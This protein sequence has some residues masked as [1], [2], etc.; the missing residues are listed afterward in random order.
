M[1]GGPPSHIPLGA[2][3][4]FD[5]IRR[6]AARWGMRAV[7]LGDDCAVLD[8]PEGERLVI[9]TDSSVE[10]VHFRRSWLSP[11]EIGWR[12]TAGALSDLAAMG[13]RPLGVMLGL[14]VPYE[15]RSALDELADGIGEAAA[16]G[17]APILGG[18]TSDGGVLALAVT[19]IGAAARPLPRSGARAGDRLYV[20]GVLGGSLGALRDLEAGRIPR[21]GM[22]QRFAHPEPR[23]R[24]G[25]WLAEQG[26]TA[27]VDI[28]DG[29]AADLGHLAAASGVRIAV[30]L[31]KLPVYEEADPRTGA[32][33]AVGG[34]AKHA[35][36][37]LTDAARSGEEYELLVTSPKPLDAARF[38]ARFQLPLTEIGR[39]EALSVGQAPE[40]VLTAQGRRVDLPPGHDHFS[41]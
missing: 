35:L 3:A 38:A 12:A 33:G 10:N 16:F 18:D 19:V 22:W 8:P 1:S 36:A 30:D 20:T 25:Q 31:D 24:E 17:G 27:A 29:L 14:V 6:L 9:S 41:S 37:V 7:G 5:A 13:A 40:V 21:P 2:G 23:L 4:E 15:W 34:A 39:A 32:F 28:S 11:R 26:V